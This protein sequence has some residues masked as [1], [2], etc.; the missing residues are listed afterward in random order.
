MNVIS[1]AVDFE[2]NAAKPADRP[3][4]VGIKSRTDFVVYHGKPAFCSK[5]NVIEEIGV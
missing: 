3:A 2:S 4:Q 5:H 1:H